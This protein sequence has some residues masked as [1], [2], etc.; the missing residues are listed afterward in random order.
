MCIRTKNGQLFKGAWTKFGQTLDM[1]KLR[2]FYFVPVKKNCMD[3]VW[4]KVGCIFVHYIFVWTNIG[5]GQ[6]LNEVRTFDVGLARRGFEWTMSGQ[7]LE[8]LVS[9]VCPV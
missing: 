8:N 6:N 5:R 7:T 2:T 4:T 3:K 1:D 9:K